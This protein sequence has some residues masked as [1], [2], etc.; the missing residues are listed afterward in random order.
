MAGLVLIYTRAFQVGQVVRI[1]DDTGTVSGKNMLVTRLRT[2]ANE[3]ITIPNSLVLAKSV[4]N[5]N[6]YTQD[7]GLALQVAVD[8]GYE[9]DWRRVHELLLAAAERVPEVLDSP[10]PFV[11]Q[12][13]LAGG[14]G[15]PDRI[16]RRD[17]RHCY[18]RWQQ[19]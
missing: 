1:G 15:G 3:E 16:R 18:R 19:T 7:E 14:L 5:L 17:G 9:V 13:S 6:A 4:T 10:Q 11:H 12:A 8:L 2:P